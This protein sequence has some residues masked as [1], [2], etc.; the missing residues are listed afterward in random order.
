MHGPYDFTGAG[1]VLRK[2]ADEGEPQPG[3]LAEQ[4]GVTEDDVD[5]EQLRKGIEVEY[6]HTSDKETAKRIALDHLA[7]LPDY[8]DRLHEME[9]EGKEE[10]GKED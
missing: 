8:Y 2:I 6:E 5:P 4:K 9:E 1:E 3:G 10:L 7:E